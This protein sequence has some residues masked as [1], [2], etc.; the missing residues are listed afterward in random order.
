MPLQAASGIVVATHLAKKILA[1][2]I[3]VCIETSANRPPKRRSCLTSGAD[4]RFEEITVRAR[5]RCAPS[6]PARDV[7]AFYTQRATKINSFEVRMSSNTGSMHNGQTTPGDRSAPPPGFADGKGLPLNSAV[8]RRAD[9]TQVSS[10]HSDSAKKRCRSHVSIQ[11]QHSASGSQRG[12]KSQATTTQSKS[13]PVSTAAPS[14]HLK[15]RHFRLSFGDGGQV[16]LSVSSR[17]ERLQQ[18]G[19]S[20][21]ALANDRSRWRGTRPRAREAREYYSPQRR[22]RYARCHLL[23]RMDAPCPGGDGRTECPNSFPGC[24]RLVSRVTFDPADL[25]DVLERY[26]IE[27]P[28]RMSRNHC[29][30][31]FFNGVTQGVQHFMD[32]PGVEPVFEFLNTEKRRGRAPR[33]QSEDGG[34]SSCTFREHPRGDRHLMSPAPAPIR[35]AF[36]QVIVDPSLTLDAGLRY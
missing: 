7:H 19:R 25:D 33:K 8:R 13:E 16:R 20:R 21:Q 27:Q 9:E 18:T 35:H 10:R 30:G 12:C 28:R 26:V 36:K 15:A 34:K 22:A 17:S 3:L 24:E 1:P 14:A 23:G 11:R 4:R 29:L 32:R 5:A 6:W 2:F 31:I